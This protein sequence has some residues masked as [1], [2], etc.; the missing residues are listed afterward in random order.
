MKEATQPPP[1]SNPQGG[2]TRKS[3][4]ATQTFVP[5]E[6]PKNK[7]AVDESEESDQIRRNPVSEGSNYGF[8]TPAEGFGP[9]RHRTEK[10][11]TP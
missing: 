1:E 11:K 8:G 10:P 6:P 9:K 5:A 2:Q 3:P 4:G 7:P